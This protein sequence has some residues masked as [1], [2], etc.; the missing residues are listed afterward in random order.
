MNKISKRTVILGASPNPQRY[1]NIAT[2]RLINHGHE[3]YPIGLRKGEINGVSLITDR[4]KLNNIDTI[5]LYIGPQ[6]QSGW[7]DY[8]L[9]LKPNRLIFNPGT[10]NEILEKLAKDNNIEVL[11]ACT[12]VLLSVGSY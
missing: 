11:E 7:I 6:N 9:E 3:V 10:E 2:E 8:I 5:T 4:P 12:L 1:A